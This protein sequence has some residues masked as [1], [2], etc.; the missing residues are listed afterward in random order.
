MSAVVGPPVGWLAARW[1]PIVV[2]ALLVCKRI[3][4]VA[5]IDFGSWAFLVPRPVNGGCP[6][7]RPFL[8]RFQ[9]HIDST[10]TAA[11]YAVAAQM[12]MK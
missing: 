4:I 5:V 2:L 11:P 9:T 12:P 7:V 1:S 6:A 8:F 10:T 3:D